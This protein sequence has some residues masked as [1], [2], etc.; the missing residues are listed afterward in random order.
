MTTAKVFMTG[1]SQAVRIPKAFR[2]GCT[3]VYV[4]RSGDSLL[5]TPARDRTWSDFFRDHACPDFTLDRTASQRP[6]KRVPFA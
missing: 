4:R 6:Q 5:L 3:E 1:R 2:F